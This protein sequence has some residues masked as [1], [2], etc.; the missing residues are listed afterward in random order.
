MFRALSLL[1]L[2]ALLAP[3][4]L[5]EVEGQEGRA[6][7]RS[8]TIQE[9]QECPPGTTLVRVGVCQ[10]PEFPAPSIVDYRP[11]TTLVVPQNPVPR[12]KFPA[13]DIHSHTGPTPETI[14]RLIK[15]M[16]A[17]NIR[18]LNNLSGGYGAELKQKTDYI[19]TTKYAGRL[20]ENCSARRCKNSCPQSPRL[21][22]RRAVRACGRRR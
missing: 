20:A 1:V 17:L 3:A 2:A 15:E 16:D 12:A 5:S 9:G 6:R 10:A 21:I 4:V 18:V 7:P 14:D 19:K 11:R 22:S 8:T 13:V